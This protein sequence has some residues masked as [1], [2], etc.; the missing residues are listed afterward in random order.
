MDTSQYLS[1]FLEESMEHLQNLNQSM[2]E[3]EN[4][5]DRLELLDQIF[6]SAHTFKGMSATMGFENLT[7]LTHKMENLLDRLRQKTLVLNADMINCLFKCLDTLE[8]MVNNIQEG[9]AGDLPVD[10]LTAEL[11]A[12]EKGE[13][14]SSAAA[15]PAE[16]APPKAEGKAE[17]K[18][19]GPPEQMPLNDI[20]LGLVIKA[21]EDKLFVWQILVKLDPSCVLKGVRAF[22]VFKK[23]EELGDV[24]KSLPSVQD[25]E[26][27]NFDMDIEVVLITQQNQSEVKNSL[28]NISEVMV[29]KILAVSKDVEPVPDDIAMDMPSDAP[30]EPAASAAAA[31]AAAA[32]APGPSASQPAAAAPAKAPAAHQT[33]AHQTVRVDIDRLDKLMTLAGELVTNKTRLEQINALSQLPELN[34]TVEQIN[35]ITTDLQSVVQ[36]VRMVPIESVFNRFP[37][38]VRD[39][40]KELGKEVNLIMEGKET[41]LDRT[42]IDE[43]GDP[44]VHLLRNSLDHGVEMPNERTAAGKN[45]VGTVKLSAHHEGNNVVITVEDDGKGIDVNAIREKALRKE[46]VTPQQLAQMDDQT[47][48]NLI[49]DAGFSTAE[50]VTDISGRGVG[51][52]VV[53]SKIQG[54]NGM[55]S[56]D[57][58]VGQGSVFTIKLPLTLAII[59]ALL[60]SVQDEIYAISLGNINETTN[61][62]VDDIK[63][64]QGQ[65]VMVLRSK[66]LP[67]VFIK[68]VL[69]VPGDK[70]RSEL[71]VVVIQKG[72]QQ[73]GLVVDELV[74]QQEIVI[75]SL[76]KL[77]TGLPGIAG[78]TTLGDGRVSMILDIGTLF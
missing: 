49:F 45:P 56:L 55:V 26:D 21:Q 8:Q 60:V 19:A 22:M 63:D 14:V 32:P 75:S 65:K 31:P 76:G 47:V 10:E 30:E 53:R 11:I 54:L 13:S 71:Y 73:F 41:E 25:I 61:L 15:A 67:L 62:D 69:D 46:V 23:L 18:A 3:L 42:V 27:E 9:G 39:L 17:K 5:P 34:E 50:K 64:I 7:H 20:E 74:G 51:L 6:R 35:R 52:D 24:I 4:D 72:D 57:T 29:E 66:V 2:L 48:L 68:D 33:V 43:I 1:L 36:T 58:K 44:M 59:Q 40:V 38:M 37:R 28:E 70:A 12:L 77:L 16:A 78:A